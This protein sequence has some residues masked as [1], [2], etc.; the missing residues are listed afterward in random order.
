MLI[1]QKASTLQL[2]VKGLIRLPPVKHVFILQL[3]KCYKKWLTKIASF[4][5]S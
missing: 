5:G 1:E 4:S 3:N 2:V